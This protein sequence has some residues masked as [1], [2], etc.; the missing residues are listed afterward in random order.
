M[1]TTSLSIISAGQQ[2]AGFEFDQLPLH[3]AIVAACE[4]ID[5]SADAARLS[6]MGDP[7]RAMEY[8]STAREAKAFAV[9]AFKGEV[10]LTVQSWAD[11]CGIT[12][13]AAAESIIL[14]A[15][16]WD[17]ALYAIRDTRLKGKETVKKLLDHHAVLLAADAAINIIQKRVEGIEVI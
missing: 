8:E 2:F 3:A 15:D 4:Q 1:K 10:P 5:E 17:A 14:K 16:A 7:L 11:A 12:P 13:Q 9:L 6:I